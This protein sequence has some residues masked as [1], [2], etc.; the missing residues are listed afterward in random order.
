MSSYLAYIEFK[1]SG[2]KGISDQLNKMVVT[3]DTLS[4]NNAGFSAINN[5]ITDIRNVITSGNAEKQLFISN[6]GPP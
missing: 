6:M 2:G 1:E 3:V 4:P 5:I